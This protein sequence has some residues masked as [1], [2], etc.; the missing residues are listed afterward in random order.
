MVQRRL[1]SLV[2]AL[3]NT[4]LGFGI[5]VY[6]GAL[7]YPLFGVHFALHE[8][9]AITAIFTVVSIIRGYIVRRVFVW[10]HIKGEKNG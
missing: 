1:V 10:L 4:A 8:L 3:S 7:V 6:A 9:T 5:S 2:E